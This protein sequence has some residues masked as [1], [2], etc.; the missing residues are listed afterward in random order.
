MRLRSRFSSRW[1]VALAADPR[2][3]AAAR[4]GLGALLLIDCFQ[5]ARVLGD[6]YTDSGVVSRTTAA[7]LWQVAFPNSLATWSLHA[8]HGSY[9]WQAALLAIEALAAIAFCVGYRAKVAS[10]VAFVLFASHCQRNVLVCHAEDW[11]MLAFLLWA[12]FLPLDRAWALRLTRPRAAAPL[13]EIAPIAFTAQLVML[14]FFAGIQKVLNSEAWRNGEAVAIV[15][16]SDIGVTVL[17]RWLGTLPLPFLE[18]LT[19]SVLVAE[20]AIPWLLVAPVP[21]AVRTG[22][23]AFIAFHLLGFAACLKIGLL[24]LVVAAALLSRLP[25]TFWD[26]RGL[27]ARPASLPD[28]GEPPPEA[29]W[30]SAL[31]I[32]GIL[33]ALLLNVF[34]LSGEYRGPAWLDSPS[35]V[36]V[37]RQGWRMFSTAERSWRSSW[38]VLFGTKRSDGIRIR[39][40]DAAQPTLGPES[41]AEELHGIFRWRLL[42]SNAPV[43]RQEFPEILT[44]ALSGHCS[45]LGLREVELLTVWREGGGFSGVPIARYRCGASGLDPARESPAGG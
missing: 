7:A 31:A 6:F 12:M 38:V 23:V 41:S 17:G 44:R 10:I 1:P 11:A 28:R 25:R 36:L 34:R 21:A 5:R 35:G 20:I 27:S 2:S 4:I 32:A 19:Y 3:I 24:P 15:L 26:A 18:A 16:R 33:H 14:L 8:L 40:P 39:L 43:L 9:I 22:A 37:P 45:A 42:W 30:V 29:R 13:L